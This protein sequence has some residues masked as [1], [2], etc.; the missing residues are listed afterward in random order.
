MMGAFVQYHHVVGIY[1]VIGRL[2]E[3]VGKEALPATQVNTHGIPGAV[4]IPY[5]EGIDDCFVFGQG[6]TQ[7]VQWGLFLN[8]AE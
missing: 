4:G 6:G 7:D 2:L 5:Q 8:K 3:Q 1:Q